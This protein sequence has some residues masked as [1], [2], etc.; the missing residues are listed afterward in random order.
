M[1]SSTAAAPPPAVTLVRTAWNRWYAPT[2][3]VRDSKL[4]GVY[5]YMV[6]YPLYLADYPL[7]RLVAFQIDARIR[8]SGGRHRRR[9]VHAA[10]IG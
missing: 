8:A 1:A 5:S 6:N 4:L 10:I 3:G 2:I 9:D 7:G